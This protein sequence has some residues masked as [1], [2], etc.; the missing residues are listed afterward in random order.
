M[1]VLIGYFGI[2]NILS[3]NYIAS[4]LNLLFFYLTWATL[5]MSQTPLRIELLGSCAMRVIFYWIP[6]LLF[7]A[8]DGLMPGL[9]S[10]LK[11]RRGPRPTGT[12]QLGIAI[13]ALINQLISAFIQGLVL[14]VRSHILMRKTPIF[15][16]GT[17]LPLPWNMIIDILFILAS[18]EAIIYV[19][20][21][22]VLHNPSRYKTLSGFHSIHHKYAKSPTFA[23]KAHYAHPLDHFVLQFLP[24]YIPAYFRR[25]HLLTF[26]LT[27]AIV[28]LES[29][30]IYSGYDI[31]W[32]FFGGTV[33]RI[34]RHHRPG[35]QYKDFGIWGFIDWVAGT[36]GSGSRPKKDGWGI[37]VKKRYQMRG[38]SGDAR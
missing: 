7:T 38:T 31:F 13:N 2:S 33:R 10:D 6:T 3:L 22:Y 37:D 12:E 19:V 14:F 27:L 26:F 17:T 18:R 24:L 30:V 20:H 35:G 25:V 9:S 8:F 5:V 16:I 15:N 28:S 4:S 34:D 36:S 23:L 21:R 29:A 32:G 1:D 11:L